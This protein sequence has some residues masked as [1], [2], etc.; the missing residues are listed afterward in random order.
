M[1]NGLNALFKPSSVAVIGASASPGKIGNEVTRN[2]MKG[3][4][5]VY[6]VNPNETEIMGV[7]CHRSVEEIPGAVDL[8]IVALPAGASVEA[9][10]GCVS[11]GVPAVIVSASGFGESGE[12]GREREEELVKA[13]SGTSTR[14]L[15]PNTMGLFV[16]SSSLDT[17]FI[18]SERSNRPGPGAV[19]LISQ[20][21]AVAVSFM[22]KA[23]AS[24][25]GISACVCVGNKCDIDEIELM[26][27][28]ADDDDTKSIAL[29]LES[30]SDG[31]RFIEVSRRVSMEKPVVLLKSGRTPAGHRAARS[32]T[33]AIAS[34]SDQVVDGALRQALVSRV[35]DE[36][37]LVDISRALSVIGHTRG[38]RVCIIASAGGFGVIGADI[39]ESGDCP[40]LQMAELSEET[41]RSLKRI[42][43]AFTS[44]QNPVDLTAGV[45]DEMYNDALEALQSD[46]GV[47]SIMMSLELQPPNVTSELIG[48]AAKRSASGMTPI[49][50]SAF[51][52]DQA[53]LLKEMARRGLVAYP[54]IKRSLHSLDVLAERGA[55]MLRDTQSGV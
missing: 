25:M 39:V 44:P 47:D 16:P 52:K 36:E 10:R 31:R 42:V 48:I 20:S 21:G 13:V 17:L 27:Y 14:I 53:S 51:A 43:P 54:T 55:R 12:E 15:G 30:F 34:S 46:P 37:S 8:A 35:S 45:T 19:A 9:V 38:G 3:D 32:H 18:S 24:G 1:S 28:L 26:E 23:E 33:G 11:K 50:V 29:Y 5:R 22:E 4:R 41:I 6:P 40:S 2:L 7:K 49:V